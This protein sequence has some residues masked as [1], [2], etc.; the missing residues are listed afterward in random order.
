MENPDETGTTRQHYQYR[1]INEIHRRESPEDD[2]DVHGTNEEDGLNPPKH[3]EKEKYN[4]VS[5]HVTE[6]YDS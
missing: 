5:L 6:V 4:N 3:L 2:G 1:N